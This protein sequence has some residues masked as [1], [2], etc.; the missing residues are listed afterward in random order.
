MAKGNTMSQKSTLIYDIKGLKLNRGKRNILQIGNLQIHRGTIYGIIGSIGSGKSSLLRLLAGLDKPSDGM[1][2]YDGRDFETNWL[3]RVKPD[4]TINLA[5]PQ[6]LDKGRSIRNLLEK[7]FPKNAN[8][9]IKRYFSSGSNKL[10]VDEPLE[11]LTAGERAWIN[12]IIAINSDPRVLLVDDY[13]IHF[14]NAMLKDFNRRIQKMTRELGTTI[15]L[16]AAV[17]DNIQNIA[18][19]LIFLDNGHICKIRPGRGRNNRNPRKR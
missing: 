10:I 9:L 18:S 15:V 6:L 19:V 3:G 14:D 16:S 5:D 8:V 2:K 17:A 4:P 7:R 11:Q 12:T 13:G 1:L